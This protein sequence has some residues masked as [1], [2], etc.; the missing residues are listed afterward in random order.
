MSFKLA[1]LIKQ[2]FKRMFLNM[3]TW[4]TGGMVQELDIKYVR[5]DFKNV[6]CHWTIY[7]VEISYDT[8]WAIGVIKV[9]Q[10]VAQ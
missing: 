8:K 10:N 6:F 3:S 1:F 9:H 2:E 7:L 5:G 4:S